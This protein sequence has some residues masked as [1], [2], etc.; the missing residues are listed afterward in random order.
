M[1]PA[2]NRVHW[3]D[4]RQIKRSGAHYRYAIEHPERRTVTREMTVGSVFDALV[5]GQ[6]N[7]ARYPGKVRNGREWEA[8]R[9]AHQ[10][11]IIC[12]Q[13]EYEE[14]ESAA[15]S[16]MS[17]EVAWPLIESARKQ[18]VMTWEYEGVPCAAGIPGQ[19]GGF[20]LLYPDAIRDLKL[21][22]N[23]EPEAIN[24]QILNMGWHEQ[25]V[26]YRHGA[27]ANGIDVRTLGILAVE[28]KPPHVVTC[29]RLDPALTELGE[30]GVRSAIER[31]KA[32]VESG[33]WPGYVQSEIE[34]SCP[35]WMQ[36][37][38]GDVDGDG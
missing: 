15:D 37:E 2:D 22:S 27:R 1:N 4:L 5:F 13:S 11:E 26:F 7:V 17:D 35:A 10:R 16:V 9:A 38:T 8:F 19:R 29:M 6:R 31:Y 20:D 25:L 21:T 28:A 30:R 18:I 32:C 14:A 23:A 33:R 12:L 3:S 24:R 34:T 36:V